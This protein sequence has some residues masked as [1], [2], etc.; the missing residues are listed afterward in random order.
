M[1]LENST[2]SSSPHTSLLPDSVY[3]PE[4]ELTQHL[5]VPF[6]TIIARQTAKRFTDSNWPNVLTT[7]MSLDGK[8]EGVQFDK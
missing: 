6:C 8:D 5:S 1:I 7:L 2:V 4:E 3:F